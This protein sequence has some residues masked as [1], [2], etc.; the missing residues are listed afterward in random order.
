MTVFNKLSNTLIIQYNIIICCRWCNPCK[1]LTPRI[2]SVIG[3]NYGKITLAKVSVH[4]SI[5]I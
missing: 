2:E 1:M 4:I 5:C 3:E